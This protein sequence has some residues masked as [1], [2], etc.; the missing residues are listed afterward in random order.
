MR[1]WL[2]IVLILTLLTPVWAQQMGVTDFK[3]K[4]K[5][6]LNYRH[7]QTDKQ[8]AL[9]DFST[10]EKGFAFLANGK[11]EAE[12]EEGEDVITVKL[13][14]KT[15]YVTIKHPDYGQYTW[16]VPAKYLKKKKRYKAKLLATDPTKEYKLQEQW[17][18]FNV[19]PKD[20]I[21]Q[22]D[23]TITPIRQGSYVRSLP[24][25]M[26]S[27]RVE[28][29]FYEAVADS[30]CLTDTAKV[31][32]S[33]KLQ[34]FYSFLTVRSR[35]PDMEIYID[36]SPVAFKE[37]TSARLTAGKHRLSMFYGESCYYDTTI[38]LAQAEKR[39]VEVGSKSL[40]RYPLKKHNQGRNMALSS[41]KPL[42][43]ETPEDALSA[44]NSQLAPITL[45]AEDEDTEIWIDRE[46]VG[47]GLWSG[48]LAQGY[49]Q[50][51]TQKDGI[52]SVPT[53]LWVTD[54]FP[55]EID[56]AVPQ[57]SMG[58]LNIRSNVV[59]AF[60]YINNVRVGETPC[61][62]QNLPGGRNCHVRLSKEGYRDAKKEVLVEANGMVELNIKL[63]KIKGNG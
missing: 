38:V 18:V 36:G 28:A 60:I 55:Q 27:Y 20:A 32:L 10:P 43:L 11:E 19:D 41:G 52:E 57:T 24:L 58:L 4:K 25:G 12:A 14:H 26:H 63:K 56:L 42:R 53:S 8:K 6:F 22:L 44:K 39:V 37:G 2:T 7:V 48:Q 23:S 13:P 59:G 31:S 40:R 15:R 9:L 49:H 35:W 21:I 3:R 62:I 47:K 29:P 51:I 5:G 33:I 61:V 17:V 46:R 50:V 30:F 1:K 16:R 45:K 34:P 54:D